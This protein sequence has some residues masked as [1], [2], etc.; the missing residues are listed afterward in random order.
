MTSELRK[1]VDKL[2]TL[3]PQLN[4]ATD[5]ANRV[6]QLVEKFLNDECKVGL[7]CFVTIWSAQPDGDYQGSSDDYKG[8]FLGYERHGGSFRIVVQRNESSLDQD[9][10]ESIVQDTRPWTESTRG[11]KLKTFSRLPELLD[12][13]VAEAERT[14]KSAEDATDTIEKMMAVLAPAKAKTP[15]SFLASSNTAREAR[16]QIE[17][18]RSQMNAEVERRL[19]E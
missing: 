5:D 10:H 2:R 18:E 16:I 12:A 17:V 13:I 4:K 8:L 3:S 6:V 1:S 14:I 11:E 9:G 15:E 19:A 7:P